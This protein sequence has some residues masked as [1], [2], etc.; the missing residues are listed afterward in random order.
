MIG[1]NSPWNTCEQRV[2]KGLF[3]DTILLFTHWRLFIQVFPSLCAQ[4]LEIKWNPE[5]FSRTPGHYW[6]S[7]KLRNFF[8]EVAKKYGI[9]NP[10]EWGSITVDMILKE[11][12]V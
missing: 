12:T 9:K 6:K 8:D 10:S 11:G 4:S 2:Q 5:W 7:E 3:N 1:E